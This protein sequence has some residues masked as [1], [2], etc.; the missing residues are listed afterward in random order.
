MSFVYPAGLWALL[1]L[2]AFAAVCLMKSRSRV[3]PVSSTYLWRLSEQRRRQK[4][5][6]R[7][8]KRAL[9]FALQGLALLLSAL[10]IAQPVVPLPGSGV[11]MAVILDASASMQLRDGSGRSR[12]ERAVAA[13]ERDM[14]KLP[15]GASV[16]VILAGDEARVAAGPVGAGAPL[17]AALTDVACGWGVGDVAGAAALCQQ[18]LEEGSIS[19]VRLYTDAPYEQAQGLEVVSLSGEDEWNVSVGALQASGSIYGTAFETTVHS[20][21]RDAEV[22][23]EL[24]VDGRVQS[25]GDIELRVEGQAQA[26]QS[27]HCPEGEARRVTLLLRQVYDFDEACVR[28]KAEDGLAQDN[29][30]WLQRQAAH[31]A[32]VL[33]VG[34]NPYFWQK[35]LGAFE[36]VELTAAADWRDA[37]LEGYDVYA[38]DGCLPDALPQ[39]GAVWLLNPPRSPRELGVVL[40]EQLLGVYVRRAQADTA[41]GERLTSGLA[42]RDVAVARF[43]EMTAQGALEDVLLCGEMPVMA[44]GKN[45]RGCVQLVMPF[46]IEDSSLP[47]LADFIVLVGNMLE[48]SAP[49]LLAAQEAAA[50][51]I[52]IDAVQMKPEFPSPQAEVAA[53]ELP[54][55]AMEGRHI[56]AAVTVLCDVQGE[57]VLRIWEGDTLLHE[58]SVSLVPGRQ[59][60][61]CALEAGQEG[62][63]TLRA[64]VELPGDTVEQ[65]D[66]RT[67][68]LNVSRGEKILLVDGT[69]TQAQALEQLLLAQGA[70]VNVT[71][72]QDVPG[73]ADELSGYG[74]TVLMNVHAGDLPP[75]WDEVLRQAVEERGRSVLT[76]GGENTYIYGGMKDTGYEALLPVRM[77][78]QEKESVDPVGLLLVIDTT[79]SMT[80][81]S[82]GV[83]IDMAKRGAIKC[84]DGLNG[85]DYAGVITF[86]D[87]AQTLVEMTPMQDK[88]PVI[89]AINAIETAGADKLTRFTGALS[90][91]CDTLKAFEGT[92]RKHV[93]FITDGSPA[94]DP[95]GFEQI[96][97][98]MRANGITLSTIVVG[99]LVNVVNMLEGLALIGG[100]RCYLVESGQDLSDIMSV[101]SVLSQVEYTISAPFKPE[102]GVY[103]AAFAGEGELLQLFGYVRTA[104]KSDADVILK[105][106]EG[107]PVYAVRSAGAGRAA[108]FMSDLSGEWSR[109]WY[110]SEQGRAQ[111]LQMIQGLLPQASPVQSARQAQSLPGE[112]D[113]LGQADGGALLMEL[114]AC[115]GG[116]VFASWEEAQAVE[117]PPVAQP[118]DL[119]LPL[120]VLAMACLLAGIVLRRIKGERG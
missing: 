98:Q 89:A 9:F 66:S 92:G 42:L 61:V 110:A 53:F 14:G 7:V 87:D 35:A 65:N 69:G 108:S 74:L 29:E 25:A 101:D 6:R 22:G 52:R 77:S 96:A 32:R 47:L 62:A 85:N 71:A 5:Y 109:A 39:D 68:T 24:V 30:A 113:L 116:T 12:F 64:Q 107:R 114:C 117:L 20:F 94:D 84:V 78:V 88:E 43:R 60:L 91:A 58:Q 63:H 79:D 75:G 23:F 16:T 18:M 105:T 36:R 72:P 93:M 82:A 40:G 10:L 86:S 70:Q 111:I 13:V 4:G 54:A 45:A 67:A 17:R 106:P 15:W 100:G 90:L 41:L 103:D 38:F 31:P 3:T 46:D 99:R 120:S 27:V 51:G 2:G 104:Q 19:G 1:A 33:L 83:P 56:E 81:E 26:G 59:E 21:G 34:E 55:G 50:A 28:A 11:N 95:A 44:A 80:R 118:L 37:A 57:A 8:L 48:A 115:T 102:R 76:T 49:Q 73:S 97:R 112:Y 119:V